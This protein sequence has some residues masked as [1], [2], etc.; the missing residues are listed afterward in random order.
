MRAHLHRAHFAEPLYRLDDV[1]LAPC[2]SLGRCLATGKL[3]AVL[4]TP[5]AAGPGRLVHE[6]TT[7]GVPRAEFYERSISER[8]ILIGVHCNGLEETTRV[9]SVLVRAGAEDLLTTGATS[10]SEPE[11]KV[12]QHPRAA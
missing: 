4:K 9:Q 6:L 12:T 10:S 8:K 3:G 1:V 7:A 2:G 11:P 5:A